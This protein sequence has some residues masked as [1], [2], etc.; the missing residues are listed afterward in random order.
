MDKISFTTTISQAEWKNSNLR[1]Y[2]KQHNQEIVHS[3]AISSSI[4]KK[5]FTTSLFQAAWVRNHSLYQYLRQY[6]KE[7][8]HYVKYFRQN[9]HELIYYISIN[10]SMNK[11]SLTQSH[12]LR[13]YLW[14]YEEELIGT[15]SFT[16]SISLAVWTR[17]H[18]HELIHYVSMNKNSLARTHSLRRYEQELIYYV[19]IFFNVNKNSF[20]ISVSQSVK[21]NSFITL[22]SHAVWTNSRSLN[23]YI[24]QAADEEPFW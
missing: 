15:N 6:E 5:W 8:I 2:L 13:R 16:T 12:S 23:Q 7:L 22:V 24:M 19:S 18:W 14:Q 4:I 1:Q 21:K 17:T 10:G 20:P 3:V 9:E 11:N